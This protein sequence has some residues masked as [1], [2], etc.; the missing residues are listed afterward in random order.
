MT[1]NLDFSDIRAAWRLSRTDDFPRKPDPK[2]TRPNLPHGWALHRMVDWEN[3]INGRWAWW[4]R[5]H[6]YF[7]QT[8][9]LPDTPIPEMDWYDLPDPRTMKMLKACME[10]LEYGGKSGSQNIEYFL[11]WILYSFGDLRVME[12]PPEPCKGASDR[13]YQIFAI[14][15]ML[16][17]P[18]DY[19]G[20]LLSEHQWGKAKGF[21]PTPMA[22][23]KMMTQINMRMGVGRGDDKDQRLL[24]VYDGCAGTGRMLMVASDYSVR[25]YAQ[26]I[27]AIVLKALKINYYLYVPWGIAPI[28]FPEK[29]EDD[30]QPPVEYDEELYLRSDGGGDGGFD[31][32]GQ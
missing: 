16:M 24:T 8:G 18:Y 1:N 29:S 12:L 5:C 30:F 28:N 19:F 32:F 31:P 17:F 23:V 9:Q 26:D 4:G 15:A 2:V 10:T 21:F 14:D 27:D 6:W 20:D 22:V 25:L 13:L 7:D 3:R 11:D